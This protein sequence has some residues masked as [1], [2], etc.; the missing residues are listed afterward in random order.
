MGYVMKIK[1]R[2]IVTCGFEYSLAFLGLKELCG[3]GFAESS[4][5][6]FGQEPDFGGG[7][8]CW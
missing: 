4:N 1:S 8:C 6:Y 3:F 5:A 7:C 2:E